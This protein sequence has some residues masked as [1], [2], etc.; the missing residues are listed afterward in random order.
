MD[1]DFRHGAAEDAA[2]S[3]GMV[4]AGNE[5]ELAD[6]AP[7]KL[8]MPLLGFLF[9]GAGGEAD[10]FQ[11]CRGDPFRHGEF[12]RGVPFVPA[13]KT[14][15]STHQDL[16]GKALT[17][18]LRAVEDAAAA[19]VTGQYYKSIRPGRRLIGYESVSDRRQ[20]VGEPESC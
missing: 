1:L 11:H 5:Q 2:S 20:D 4:V 9:G 10:G 16:W 7:G 17:D 19:P 3:G 8:G 14:D 15:C 13:I 6:S 12:Y 18:E